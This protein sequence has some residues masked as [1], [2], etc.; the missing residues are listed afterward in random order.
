MKIRKSHHTNCLK[1]YVFEFLTNLE[2]RVKDY[3]IMHA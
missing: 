3:F 2:Q 1:K